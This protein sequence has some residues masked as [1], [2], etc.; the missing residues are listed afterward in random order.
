MILSYLPRRKL[1]LQYFK[2]VWDYIKNILTFNFITLICTLLARSCKAKR[3]KSSVFNIIIVTIFTAFQ[4]N[5]EDLKKAGWSLPNWFYGIDPDGPGGNPPFQVS[6][7]CHEFLDLSVTKCL[8]LIS[9]TN[10]KSH[11]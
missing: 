5:C 4:K 3:H 10:L 9:P 11:K 8:V 2:A 6:I 1:T 7:R